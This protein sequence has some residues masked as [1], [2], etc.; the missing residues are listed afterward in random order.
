MI[1]SPVFLSVIRLREVE[2]EVALICSHAP[3]FS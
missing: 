1:T 2:I 3:A